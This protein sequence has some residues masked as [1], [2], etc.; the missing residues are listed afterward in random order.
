MPIDKLQP[1]F[2]N[3]DD[4]ERLISKIEMSDAQ[5]VRT[6][7]DAAGN[8]LV[9][10][11]AL[12]NFSRSEDANIQNGSMPS[13]T[14]ICVGSCVS[15]RLGYVYWFVYNSG[16][17]HTILRY[18]I[19]TKKS[20]I[21]YQDD[22][23]LF[24]AGTRVT[25]NVIENNNDD[26][27]LYF[28]DGVNS[29]KKINATV[30]EQS[31]SG[32]GGYPSVF[33]TGTVYERL[34]YVTAAKQPP[35]TPPVITFVNNP[36][37]GQTDIFEKNF[38]FSYQYIYRDGEQSALSP[39]TRLGVSISQLKDGF[40]TNGQR[41][42][43]NQINLTLQSSQADV[44]RIKVYARKGDL[45]TST[46]YLIDEI[47]NNFNGQVGT[48]QVSFSDDQAFIPLSTEVQDKVYDN[49]PQ[50]ADS[51]AIANG[52]LMYGG[53][54]DGYP[55][56][57]LG[58]SSVVPNYNATAPIYNIS[59]N[60]IQGF[61]GEAV[62]KSKRFELDFSSLP[63]TITEASKVLVNF[64]YDWGK[65]RLTND[66]GDTDNYRW[67]TKGT[68]NL[69]EISGMRWRNTDP[70][71]PDVGVYKTGLLNGPPTIKFTSR[72]GT[73]NA[74]EEEVPLARVRKGIKL[75]SSGV[76]VEEVIDIPLGSNEQPITNIQAANIVIQ[77]ITR[78]YPFF[79]Q[80][81]DGTGG[82]S[83]VTTSNQSEAGAE[84]IAFR[85][86]GFAR[87]KQTGGGSTLVRQMQVKMEK[88][89]LQ[90][91]KMVKGVKPCE[92]ISPDADISRFDFVEGSNS[93]NQTNRI[94][95]LNNNTTITNGR[96]E[97]PT[98]QDQSLTRDGIV[99]C[100][101]ANIVIGS[102]FFVANTDANGSKCFKSGSKHQLGIILYDDRGRPGGVQ[103]FDTV[104]IDHT[105]NRTSE[106]DLDGPADVVLRLDATAP[107]W[108]SYYAPV[109]VGQGSI[110][111]KVQYGI[112]GAYLASNYNGLQGGFG[113]NSQIFL[114]LRTLQGKSNSYREAFGALIEYKYSQGD[115]LRIVRYGNNDKTTFEFNV[116][117]VES[118]DSNVNTN[119]ILDRSSTFAINNTTGDFLS[120]EPNE[121]AT[122]F[123]PEDILNNASFWNDRCVVE[124]FR[125]NNAFESDVYF[126]VG[127]VLGV[128][129]GVY[130]TARTATS[131][132]VNTLTV[133][134]VLSFYSNQQVY[135]GD[136]LTLNSD[137]SKKITV[138]NVTTNYD[139]TLY[140]YKIHVTENIGIT[141]GTSNAMTVSNPNAVVQ[142]EQGNSYFRLRT[143]YVA[144]APQNSDVASNA[145][146]AFTQNA[147]VGFIEDPNVSDFYVS[148]FTSKGRP[149]AYQPEARTIKRRGSVTWSD[150]FIVDTRVLGLSSFN[151][152]KT[153][154]FDYN[155]EYGSIKSMVSYD[156]I[157][158]IIQE[159]RAGIIPVSRNIVEFGD[160][161]SE[162]TASKNIVGPIQY[163]SGNYGCNNNPESVSVWRD[164]VFF[165]DV[166]TGKVLMVS[167]KSGLSVLSD[168][169]VDSFFKNNFFSLEE[170]A[171]NRQ[172]IAGVDYDNREFL[173]SA[174][175]VN[176]VIITISDNVTGTPVTGTGAGRV[177]NG[178]IN[179]DSIFSD[180]STY[181]WDS[182]P[183]E[184]QKDQDKFQDS[185]AGL[186]IIDTLT[187]LQSIFLATEFAPTQIPMPDGSTSIGL[188]NAIPIVM[189]TS[190]QAAFSYGTYN[191]STEEITLDN[192][193]YS[194][195]TTLGAEV[196]TL[197]DFTIGYDCY[198]PR[199]NNK[200]TFRPER[201]QSLSDQLYTFKAGRIYEHAEFFGT[202]AVPRC[203]YYG[204]FTG[205]PPTYSG[206]ARGDAIIEVVSNFNPSMVKAYEALSLEGNDRWA[207]SLS[208]TDQATNVPTTGVASTEVWQEKEGFYYAP[209]PRN[210]SVVA[211]GDLSSV[212]GTSQVFSIGTLASSSTGTTLLF[213][214]HINNSP[215]PVGT[216]TALYR[217]NGSNLTPLNTF[218]TAIATNKTL[219]LNAAATVSADDIIVTL[220]NSAI[221]GDVM[222][223]YYMKIR[224]SN[225][226]ITPVE[227]YAINAIYAKSPLANQLGQ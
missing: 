199:W 86:Q 102:N 119:P 181:S 173:I 218:A 31:F 175:S 40:I 18:D 164:Q 210:T 157:M 9:L 156:E 172:I 160:G 61:N 117:G 201:I 154:F 100:T 95:G 222:R 89:T 128:N 217:V 30:A 51:Q 62:G 13:G 73:D 92:V 166:K 25:G 183:R 52:R 96:G 75:I 24:N 45:T 6:S 176:T 143:L 188:N 121:S 3:L 76:Q 223:D 211:S 194:S 226:T 207:C 50:L 60:Q 46:F 182:D 21:V 26:V 200:Y 189:T 116:T 163:Y 133:D 193:T 146:S 198:Q 1:Q 112:G 56:V 79:V 123:R 171:T 90:V 69:D 153:N 213:K 185:G 99:N 152:T 140:T 214:N 165:A 54:T 132:T 192:T 106:N 180:T 105:N 28:V 130:G 138:G 113:A 168:L 177:T 170:S 4:D 167:Q 115:R 72:K 38:Q 88:L 83:A 48:Q 220:A 208:N 215:F 78:N 22:L 41:N 150:P 224:A 111:N 178:K 174:D 148:N 107:S 14:N 126:E 53:Y 104:E 114:S 12:G 57:D 110:I 139:N 125:E 70:L 108:A 39:Y 66:L 10:R 71:N 68:S 135:K 34:L 120:I 101:G 17:D 19:T 91:D 77:A 7:V 59:V 141:S 118:L 8:A 44:V 124:I 23:L 179:T 209:I 190:A 131:I 191:Q 122:G 36:A 202:T 225:S 67:V 169:N 11:N 81:Q 227:L 43:F 158:Y 37:L 186:L 33:R 137:T 144:P 29:P 85:G 159:R 5:N 84:K 65:I 204:K 145:I 216:N 184:Y 162:I 97:N 63:A 103:K 93:E 147:V 134:T 87:I 151:L 161:K 2:L 94:V 32:T 47:D 155:Y 74:E 27:L 129:N 42:F 197:G 187:S 64:V 20:Y 203:T 136:I 221:E 98:C 109:Y 212:D 35:L 58:Q 127:D 15:E 80:P 49:V 142:I 16:T 219:T 195:T 205:S 82:F 206:G 55:N 149:F 196:E